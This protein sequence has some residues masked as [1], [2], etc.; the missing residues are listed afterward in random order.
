[1]LLQTP[2]RYEQSVTPNLQTDVATVTRNPMPAL[3]YLRF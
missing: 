3:Q 2:T 1:M